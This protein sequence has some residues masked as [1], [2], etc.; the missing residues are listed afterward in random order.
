MRRVSDPSNIFS[1]RFDVVEAGGNTVAGIPEDCAITIRG[2]RTISCKDFLEELCV[3]I[4]TCDSETRYGVENLQNTW[5][6]AVEDLTFGGTIAPQLFL[7]NHTLRCV[8]IPGAKEIGS[9]AF[10]ECLSLIEFDGPQV[11]VIHERAFE[12]CYELKSIRLGWN[13]RCD[14]ADAVAG[15]QFKGCYQLLNFCL[16]VQKG[17]SFTQEEK[18]ARMEAIFLDFADKGV[19]WRKYA[20]C[21]TEEIQ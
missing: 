15:Y 19:E 21:V 12:G 11:A 5:V 1:D 18:I 2:R 13:V 17:L 3:T 14:R 7:C 8:K 16:V 6:K 9:R 10:F 4:D 20:K